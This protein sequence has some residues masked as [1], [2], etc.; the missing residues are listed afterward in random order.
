[1]NVPRDLLGQLNAG[2][3]VARDAALPGDVLVFRDT[4]KPGPSHA[5]LYLGDGR[6]I[7]AVDER[8]GVAI[9]ALSDGYWGPRFYG[10]GRP[11]L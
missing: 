3:R 8:H 10:A 1:V 4:Y 5:G 2:R 11:I 7:H 6:F 9:S